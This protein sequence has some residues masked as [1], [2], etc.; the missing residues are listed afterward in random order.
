MTL[1]QSWRITSENE[2]E[3]DDEQNDDQI[4]VDCEDEK[5]VN[6]II[7]NNAIFIFMY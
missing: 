6:F 1:L 3:V 5:Y 2:D 4:Y 7:N